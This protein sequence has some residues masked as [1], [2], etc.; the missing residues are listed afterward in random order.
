MA[1][2]HWRIG[3]RMPIRVWI[4]VPKMGTVAIGDPDPDWNL[5][6][7]PCDGNN[8]CTVQCGHYVWSPNP[9]HDPILC[10]AM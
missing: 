8:V 1:Y 4:S 10:L 5:S 6:L 7:S 9:S 2:L 3:T